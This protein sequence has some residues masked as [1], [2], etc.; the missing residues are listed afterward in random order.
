MKRFPKRHRNGLGSLL[1]T[2]KD[3]GRP[4][5]VAANSIWTCLV[6][7]LLVCTSTLVA[8]QQE[9]TLRVAQHVALGPYLTDGEGR[10]LYTVVDAVNPL[11]GIDARLWTPLPAEGTLM[12]AGEVDFSLLASRRGDD[13]RLQLTYGGWPLYTFVDDVGEGDL[14]GQ[15]F[16]DAWFVV[17][18]KGVPLE[19]R[20]LAPGAFEALELARQAAAR[21]RVEGAAPNPDNP[22]WAEAIREG[23]Q[24]RKLDPDEPEVVRFLAD[25]YS[26]VRWYIRAWNAWQDYVELGGVLDAPAREAGTRAGTQLAYAQYDFDRPEAALE[27]YLD[28]IDFNPTDAQAYR[29]AGR[30]LLEQ[31]RPE[32][33]LP[34]WQEAARLAPSDAGV[35]YFLRLAEDEIKYGIHGTES[36]YDGI[37]LY[38]AGRLEAALMHFR[39]AIVANPDF[40]QAFVWAGRVSLELKDPASARGYWREVLA[41]DPEDT[42][43]AFFL[44]LATDQLRWGIEAANAFREGVRLYEEGD[45]VAAKLR[46]VLATQANPEYSEAWAWTGRTEFEQEA[47]RL[48]SQAYGVA[49]ELEPENET[50]QYFYQEALRRAEQ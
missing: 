35:A 47:Y 6:G 1:R 43:A 21:A 18:T 48:A 31:A 46:F 22:L 28:V 42:R 11:A 14:Q 25:T 3:R 36:F 27:L 44:E 24:A 12:I 32:E 2:S 5:S 7:L 37:R 39:Q 30:I 29:W 9:V 49:Q 10:A 23:E 41:I 15:G 20:L 13:G 38:E 17:S 4:R 34:Y 16:Q 50:Y 33:S 40:K 19:I 26:T 45:L 8:A